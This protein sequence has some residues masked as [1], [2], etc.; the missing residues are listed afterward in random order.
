MVKIK[1]RTADDGYYFEIDD[2]SGYLKALDEQG[3]EVPKAR[4]RI[5]IS[6]ENEHRL[7]ETALDWERQ[8]ESFYQLGPSTDIPCQIVPT[9]RENNSRPAE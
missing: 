2:F 3:I 7:R 1:K 4:F 9:W 8:I 6:F 5:F